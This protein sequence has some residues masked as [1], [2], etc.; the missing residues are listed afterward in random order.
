VP[1]ALRVV[2]G[3]SFGEAD[4]GEVFVQLTRT[5]NVAAKQ[6]ASASAL[7]QFDALRMVDAPFPAGRS[8]F[9]RGLGSALAQ[10]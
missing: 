5:A 6:H 4:N 3:G 8:D 1:L 10:I 9:L 2:S 7:V